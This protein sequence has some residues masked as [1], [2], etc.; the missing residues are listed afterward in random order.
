MPGLF[1]PIP[2]KPTFGTV[3]PLLY[4]SDYLT[5]KKAKLLNCNCYPGVTHKNYGNYYSY[6][7]RRLFRNEVNKTNLVYGLYSKENLKYVETLANNTIP[8]IPVIPTQTVN[9]SN[10]PFYQYYRIDPK[11]ELFGNTPCGVNNFV[12]YM[13]PDT[14]N[15]NLLKDVTS[16][17]KE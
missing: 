7:D 15:I 5:N 16:L 2:A 8:V 12:N 9:P 14:S 6:I 17:L 3:Q 1:A 13:E 4:S 11:G 10:I